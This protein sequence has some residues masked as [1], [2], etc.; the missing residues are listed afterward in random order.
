MRSKAL[1]GTISN[2]ERSR[3]ADLQNPDPD[4]QLAPHWRVLGKI[5][6]FSSTYLFYDKCFKITSSHGGT[7]SQ[8]VRFNRG[9]SMPPKRCCFSWLKGWMRA[10]TTNSWW[11]IFIHRGSLSK[12][13]Q[14]IVSKGYFMIFQPSVNTNYRLFQP[15]KCWRGFVVLWKQV[16]QPWGSLNGRRHHGSCS[17]TTC[18]GRMVLQSGMSTSC[19]ST[20]TPMPKCWTPPALWLQEGPW[21]NGGTRL[22]GQVQLRERLN[23]FWWSYQ[24]WNAWLSMPL[25]WSHFAN[26]LCLQQ[27]FANQITPKIVQSNFVIT[28]SWLPIPLWDIPSEDSRYGAPKVCRISPGPLG[29]AGRSYQPRDISPERHQDDAGSASFL[30]CWEW[31]NQDH[32]KPTVGQWSSNQLAQIVALDPCFNGWLWCQQH[33]PLQIYDQKIQV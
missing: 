18:L 7:N 5:L 4:R 22:M 1:L 17:E 20:M 3:V 31:P 24:P 16:Q 33:V 21:T 13:V 27:L 29:Q 26:M 32:G 15:I 9:A 2:V 11:W 12:H 8:S 10:T 19:P 28:W 30:R 14:T 25:S 6:M 23:R